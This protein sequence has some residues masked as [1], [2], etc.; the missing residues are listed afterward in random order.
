MI[1]FQKNLEKCEEKTNSNY[2]TNNL[3]ISYKN[4]CRYFLADKQIVLDEN[5]F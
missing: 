3:E 5:I 4:N 1:F 2:I